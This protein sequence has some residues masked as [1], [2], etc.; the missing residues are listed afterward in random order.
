MQFFIG[1]RFSFFILKERTL[2]FHRNN[3]RFFLRNQAPKFCLYRLAAPV[4]SP[5]F[6]QGKPKGQQRPALAEPFASAAK[7]M[8]EG[9]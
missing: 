3:Y 4:V 7:R 9:V 5:A 1:K 2:F 6:N 8:T